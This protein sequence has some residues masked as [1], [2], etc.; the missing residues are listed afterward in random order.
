M[1][2]AFD[3]DS[4]AILATVDATSDEHSRLLP[5]VRVVLPETAYG[6]FRRALRAIGID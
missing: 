2:P 4:V 5:S 6:G 3:A 1:E